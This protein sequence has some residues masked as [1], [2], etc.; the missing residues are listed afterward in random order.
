MPFSQIIPPSPSPTQSNRLFYTSVSLLLSRIHAL[1]PTARSLSLG[2][3]LGIFPSVSFKSRRNNSEQATWLIRGE[4][5]GTVS[6]SAWKQ[7]VALRSATTHEGLLPAQTPHHG[8]WTLPATRT[9][10][11]SRSLP[12]SSLVSGHPPSA[13]IAQVMKSSV[14]NVEAYI[15]SGHPRQEYWSGFHFLLQGVFPTQDR[16]SRASSFRAL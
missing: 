11:Q 2:F 7:G 16:A 8:R 3:P 13:C 9:A 12:Y 6:A 15:L 10:T 4:A 1:I 14:F 5:S